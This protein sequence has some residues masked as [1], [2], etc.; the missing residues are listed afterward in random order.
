M[1]INIKIQQSIKCSRMSVH[2]NIT[3]LIFNSQSTRGILSLLMSI[4][5]NCFDCA[6]R[7]LTSFEISSMHFLLTIAELY[8]L[9]SI[10]ELKYKRKTILCLIKFC[11]K[12]K[13]GTGKNMILAQLIFEFNCYTRWFSIKYAYLKY[14][15]MFLVLIVFLL[16]IL[17]LP[18][19]PFATQFVL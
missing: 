11:R 5:I 1:L 6:I 18:F 8:N 9:T 19:S 12:E 7:I 2:D 15:F 16:Y 4:S 3:I 13:L 10:S 17:L 14:Y